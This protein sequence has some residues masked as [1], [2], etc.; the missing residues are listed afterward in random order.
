MKVCV[1][2]TPK[3]RARWSMDDSFY[4][5]QYVALAQDEYSLEQATAKLCQRIQG[6]RASSLPSK[7]PL[8]S[9]R[10]ISKQFAYCLA[11]WVR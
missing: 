9:K 4:R 8:A 11:N 6:H 5:Y 3:G 10:Q 2:N 7:A 1:D